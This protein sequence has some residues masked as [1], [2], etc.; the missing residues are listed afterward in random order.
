MTWITR[1][2]RVGNSGDPS[3]QSGSSARGRARVGRRLGRRAGGPGPGGIRP[4]HDGPVRP[5]PAMGIGIGRGG[6]DGRG[7]RGRF[8]EYRVLSWPPPLPPPE[9]AGPGVRRASGRMD[10]DGSDGTFG[11][12]L[13]SG[14]TRR[15]QRVYTDTNVMADC[16]NDFYADNS[17][18]A[19]CFLTILC[20]QERSVQRTEAPTHILATLYR[21][22]RNGRST[23]FVY[24][25]IKAG[26]E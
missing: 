15:C 20:R 4:R 19:D 5:G 3:S 10:S 24:S 13:S 11:P 7:G 12:A 2:L 16:S 1:S 23:Y 22:W 26:R 9:N 21:P 25:V 14:H 18:M 17:V 8:L 6:R